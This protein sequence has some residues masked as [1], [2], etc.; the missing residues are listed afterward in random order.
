M[1]SENIRR[2]LEYE[3]SHGDDNPNRLGY[4]SFVLGQGIAFSEEDVNKDKVIGT[5]AKIKQCYRNSQRLAMKKGLRH[6]EGWAIPE[7][8]QEIRFPMNHAWCV[9]D[10]NQVID[11]TWSN[12]TEYFGIEIGL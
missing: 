12:V 4:Y 6:F 10:K 3:Q 11:I 5:R 1:K 7:I 8:A 9:N 2:Y